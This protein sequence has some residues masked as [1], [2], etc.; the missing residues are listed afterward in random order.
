M[1]AV[2][3]VSPFSEDNCR[4]CGAERAGVY[5][6]RPRF[7]VRRCQRCTTMWCDPLR[8]NE[9]FNPDNEDAYLEVDDAIAA[10]D[11]LAARPE[12]DATRLYIH[13]RLVEI[14]CMHG[15]FI[16]Q[17]RRAGYDALGLDLSK[18]A[19][20]YAAEH[21][22]G[23]VDYGTLDDQQADASLDVVAAYNVVEH[24]EDPGT[25]LDHVHRVLRPGGW[26]FA[27]TPAQE[28]LYHWAFM[29]RGFVKPS[30]SGLEVGMHPGTHIF[31]F[32]RKAWRKVLEPRGFSLTTVH[33]KSTPLR[34]LLAKNK[35]TPLLF[36][37][38]IVGVG[39]LAR[40]TGLGNR[41]LIAAQRR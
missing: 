29:A 7:V 21:R 40:A 18:T 9:T 36:R 20:D 24:M 14:G 41:V 3:A 23:M 11:T 8:F 32:G 22:P 6:Q 26:F 30:A 34:E 39:A 28:S 31:K 33:A 16:E 17:A 15:D 35:R 37:G 38:G 19:V 12:V 1:I 10:I 2:V 27:E 4:L 25:F 13:P 5:L